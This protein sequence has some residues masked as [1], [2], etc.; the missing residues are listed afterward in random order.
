MHQKQVKEIF[1]RNLEN[2]ASNHVLCINI[3]TSSF[4][5]FN[6]ALSVPPEDDAGLESGEALSHAH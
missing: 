1:S 4:C 5:L 2:P 6:V 3:S